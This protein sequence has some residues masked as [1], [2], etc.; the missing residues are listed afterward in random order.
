[1]SCC[2]MSQNDR[3]AI[4]VGTGGLLAIAIFDKAD[5]NITVW[6][7]RGMEVLQLVAAMIG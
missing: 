7:D 6:Y 5:E 1:M 2:T 3:Q 4:W